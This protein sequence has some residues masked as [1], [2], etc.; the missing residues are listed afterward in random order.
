MLIVAKIPKTIK[1]RSTYLGTLVPMRSP[2]NAWFRNHLLDESYSDQISFNQY[3]YIYIYIYIYMDRCTLQNPATFESALNRTYF[4]TSTVFKRD[5]AEALTERLVKDGVVL[6]KGLFIAG[7]DNI[8][9]K[10]LCNNLYKVF[11]QEELCYY[12]QYFLISLLIQL[13]SLPPKKA[14]A[15]TMPQ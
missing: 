9:I 8:V 3:I 11:L 1:G 5:C 2:W 7:G 6:A 4:A 15:A 12:R 13:R 10:S 14:V